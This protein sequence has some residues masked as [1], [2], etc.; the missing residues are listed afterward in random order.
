MPPAL[1]APRHPL[2]GLLLAQFFGAFND[3]AWKWIVA[4]LAIGAARDG[5]GGHFEALAQAR[6][7]LVFVVFTLPLALFSLPAGALVDRRSKR[8]IIVAMKGVEVLLMAAGTVALLVD[9]SGYLLPLAVLGLMGAQSALFS[10][11]KYGILPEILPHARLSSGNALLESCTFLAVIAGSAAGGQLLHVTGERAWIGGLLLT[12]FA[13]VGFAAALSVP[14]VRPSSAEGGVLTTVRGAWAAM[15]A[16]RVLWL[17]VLGS[18]FFWAVASLLGQDVLVYIKTVLR[19]SDALSGVPLAVFGVGVGAGSLLAAR[20]SASKVEYGLI[21]L[22][23]VGLAVFTFLL[24]LAAPGFAGTVVLMALLGAASGLLIVPLNALVQW[25]APVDRKGGVIALANVFVFTGILAG[26]LLAQG[27]SSAG[28]S[29]RGILMGAAA[30]TAAGT[31]WALKVLPDA[32]LRLILILLTHT[33][34]RLRVVGRENVPESGGALLVPNHVSFV[35]GLLVLASLDR[36]VRFVVDAEYFYFPLWSPFLKALGAIPISASGGPR[37]VLRALRDAGRFLDEGELVCIFA[38][39]QITRTGMM[40]PFRRGLERIVKGRQTAIIPTHLDRVWGSIFSRSGGRFLTKIPERVPYPVTVS[41]GT[42]LPPEVPIYEVRRAV[43]ELGESATTLRREDRR[44][45]HHLFLRQARRRPFGFAFADATRPRVS[46]IEAAAGAVA[47]A[48]VLRPHWRGH[49]FVG[50]LLPPSVAG[51]LVNVAAALAG[52][53]SVNLNFTTGPAGMDSAAMQAGLVTIVTS[54]VFLE[55]AKIDLPGRLEPIWIEDL[56]ASIGSGRRLVSFLLACLAPIRL[57]EKACG[58]ER[59]PTLD[60]VTTVIFS[61]GSTG[62]P[63]GVLLTHANVD[64]NVEAVAQVMQ[65]QPADRV[66][67]ILPLFHSFG[68]LI[69]WFAANHRMGVVFNPSPL[70]TGAIGSLV[71][72]Y[73]VTILVATPTFLQLYLRRCTPAQFGS[74]RIVLAGAEKLSE[75]TA[76]AFEDQFGIR[77][78]EGYGTTECAPVIAVSTLDYRAPGF[79]QPGSRRGFV[80][81]PLPGVSVRIVEPESFAPL[82][83]GTPGMLLVKGPNIMRGYLGRSDL[84]AKAIRDGWYITGDIALM[85]EDGF[86]RITDRLSRFSKIGGEMVPHGRVEEALLEAAGAGVQV[87]AVTAVPDERKGESLAV[88]HTLDE[89]LLPE[90]LKK[91]AAAGLPNLFMPRLDHFVKVEKLPIMG[92]GKIDLREVKRIASEA[93]ARPA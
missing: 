41:F 73:R 13:L 40:Q 82:P 69:L 34:Y 35:D 84:T 44:P 1:L 50:I 51:A 49:R 38:E 12:L 16:D 91:V 11:A 45:L 67:G 42:P 52:R 20:L 79:Y 88:L 57:L 92:T 65:V 29:T 54:R 59:S 83:P 25:R 23:A 86:I 71:Q 90:I 30:V 47:L 81:Q 77:P 33:V 9:P 87:F 43:H 7:T 27:M 48:R 6:A 70:D 68:Y 3:N 26:S 89:A 78:L 14:E 39:G 56:S 24:G 31:L 66:L 53:T 46:R 63:K 22:G 32:L 18:A 21:P 58:A 19:V 4:L 17:A 36:P 28:L 61:S 72:R 80:G 75:R 15:R 64:A 37:V 60:D 5:A 8:S 55:K 85:D 93:L 74:L 2:R 62:D 10:P 76:Q